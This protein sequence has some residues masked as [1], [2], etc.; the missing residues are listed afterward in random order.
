MNKRRNHASRRSPWRFLFLAI[1]LCGILQ[2]LFLI[3]IYIVPFLMPVQHNPLSSNSISLG[4]IGG[5]DGPTA[6]LVTSPGWANFLIPLI[7]TIVGIP[8]YLKL[9]KRK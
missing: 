5:A 7:L 8:G 3:G 2:L 4:I 1:A 6:V 9:R